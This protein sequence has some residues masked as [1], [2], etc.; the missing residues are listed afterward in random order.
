ME[1]SLTFAGV[2]GIIDPPRAE[3]KVAIADAHRAG[4]RVVMITGDHPRTAAR[5]AAE[6]R[7]RRARARDD[8]RG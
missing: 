6:S 4:I 5:I 3:A 8:V 1:H 7:D 2:V